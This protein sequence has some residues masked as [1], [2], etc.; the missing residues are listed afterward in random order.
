MIR[1]QRKRHRSIWVAMAITLPV[2]VALA[3]MGT[4][5]A[6]G[7]TQVSMQSAA[8]GSILK[9]VD[10]KDVKVN[11][12]GAGQKP[13]QLEVVVK[14]PLK[15]ASAMVYLKNGEAL[16]QVGKRGVYRFPIKNMPL[17]ISIKD[18]IKDQELLTIEL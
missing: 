13:T 5:K 8:N 17:A 18:L 7:Q 9:E 16:G 6:P 15:A 14:V 11:I 3:V 2:L 1:A 10:T 4:P 12:R